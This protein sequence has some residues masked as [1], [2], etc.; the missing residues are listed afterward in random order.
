MSAY[1]RSPEPPV[2]AVVYDDDGAVYD[3]CFAWEAGQNYALHEG[4]RVEAVADDGAMTAEAAQRLYDADR[5]AHADCWGVA[6]AEP[7]PTN[8]ETCP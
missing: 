2:V 1:T 7:T 5:A 3:R 8:E 6:P 4:R